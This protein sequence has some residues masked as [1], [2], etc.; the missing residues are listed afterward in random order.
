M[1]FIRYGSMK[2]HKH[3]ISDD[4]VHTPPVEMGIYAFPVNFVGPFLLSGI[5]YGSTQ[6]GRYKYAK[7]ENRKKIRYMVLPDSEIW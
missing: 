6:N 1:K 7:D 5:G 2:P 4:W 3:D